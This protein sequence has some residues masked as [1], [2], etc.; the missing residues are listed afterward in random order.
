MWCTLSSPAAFLSGRNAACRSGLRDS[1]RR[2]MQTAGGSQQEE[3]KRR[4]QNKRLRMAR[5]GHR[6]G[7]RSTVRTPLRRGSQALVSPLLSSALGVPHGADLCLYH[8]QRPRYSTTQLGS[9]SSCLSLVMRSRLTPYTLRASCMVPRGSARRRQD[10]KRDRDVPRG[11]T[12]RDPRGRAPPVGLSARPDSLVSST[13]PF[14]E[15]KGGTRKRTAP[16]I[17]PLNG[18]HTQLPPIRPSSFPIGS[19]SFQLAGAPALVNCGERCSRQPPSR[20]AVL[21]HALSSAAQPRASERGREANA[22]RWRTRCPTRGS[23]S[24]P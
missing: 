3:R 18:T 24:T 16:P 7:G 1:A 13:A 21:C 20:L 23:G 6:H 12:G 17:R 14:R 8:E 4:S 11:S 9:A 5:A 19:P 15:K 10:Q 22:R 2:R